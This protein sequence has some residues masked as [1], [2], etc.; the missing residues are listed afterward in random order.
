MVAELPCLSSQNVIAVFL[1]VS[2]FVV[3]AVFL[4]VSSRDCGTYVA[5]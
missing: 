4:S 3:V 1:S 2:S 5:L